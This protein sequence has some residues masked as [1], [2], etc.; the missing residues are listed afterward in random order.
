MSDQEANEL[1]LRGGIEAYNRRDVEAM[2]ALFDPEIE[3]HVDAAQGNPG[4]WYGLDGFQE[5]IDGW[6]DVFAEDRSK[7]LG[8]EMVGD[9]H[10]IAEMR[11]RASDRGAGSRWR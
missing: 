6:R 1:L 2:V 3:L 7:V 9:R 10:L 8:I 11:Q 5:M 4:T